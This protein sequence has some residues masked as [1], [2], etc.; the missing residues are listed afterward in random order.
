MQKRVTGLEP[1]TFSLGSGKP[2]PQP[3]VATGTYEDSKLTP[4]DSHGD[5][6]A[7]DAGDPRLARLID[8]WP[9]LPE[10][11]RAGITAMVAATEP[12]NRG[13]A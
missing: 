11:L 12:S 2:V 3:A 5:S 10:A 7:M 8:S 9:N 13:G 1:A 4:G 6:Q